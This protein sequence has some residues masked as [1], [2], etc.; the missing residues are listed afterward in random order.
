MPAYAIANLSNV[1]FN[2]D[3]VRY[4]QEIDDTL[5]P[6]GG[7]FI[8]HGV[9]PEVIEGPWPDAT[10]IIEFGDIDAA[11]AWYASPAYR[12]LLPLRTRNSASTAAIVDGVPDGYRAASFLAKQ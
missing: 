3:I 9:T 12:E 2:A 4:L 1:D 8:V 10:V 11:R 6:F 7:R 5:T